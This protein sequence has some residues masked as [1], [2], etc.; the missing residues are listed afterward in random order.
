MKINEQETLRGTKSGT[1]LNKCLTKKGFYLYSVTDP[2]EP[3]RLLNIT[4]VRFGVSELD[5][6]DSQLS[7]EFI[8]DL[9]PSAERTAL[10]Y[11]LSF[12]CLGGFPKL[13]RMIRDQAIETQM[14]FGSSEAVLLKDS[15]R[16]QGWNI[17]IRQTDLQLKLA[18]CKIQQGVIPSSVHL[19]E[20]QTCLDQIRQILVDLK[21]F[22]EKVGVTL[23]SVKDKTFVGEELIAELEDMK[24]EFLESIE[25]AKL[26][27]DC[28]HRPRAP[29]IRQ[30]MA[31]LMEGGV[32]MM[33]SG[34]TA[35]GGRPME[36]RQ[37][38]SRAQTESWRTPASSL[39]WETAAMYR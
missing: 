4:N 8:Q 13:E 31:E 3:Q 37:V 27:D 11:H 36:T 15:L 24:E 19:T 16:N 1:Y 26:T 35:S 9:L 7:P 17:K 33:L 30:S 20:V 14:L 28:W 22:W 2:I 12:L 38:D 5:A 10:L 39:A 6:S 25:E 32:Q 23:D 34:L 21:K 18:N 29:Q